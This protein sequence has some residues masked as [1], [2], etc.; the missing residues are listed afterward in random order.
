MFLTRRGV[1]LWEGRARA[2]VGGM[3]KLEFQN[4]NSFGTQPKDWSKL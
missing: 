3:M 2:G 4:I 1:F